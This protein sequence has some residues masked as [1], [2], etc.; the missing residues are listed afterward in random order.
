MIMRS[1]SSIKHGTSYVV[2]MGVNS[3]DNIQAYHSYN[4]RIKINSTKI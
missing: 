1:L 4:I 3:E 2:S